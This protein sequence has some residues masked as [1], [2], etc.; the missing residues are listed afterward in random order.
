MQRTDGPAAPGLE[1]ADLQAVQSSHE[2][3]ELLQHLSALG[4]WDWDIETNVAIC[5]SSYHAL[6]GLPPESEFPSYEVWLSRLHPDDQAQASRDV[7]EALDGKGEYLSEYRVIWPDGTVH[8]L[9]GMGKVFFDEAGNPVRMIGINFDITEKVQANEELQRYREHLETLVEERTSAL[10]DRND[11]LQAEIRE[12]NRA[13][14]SLRASEERLLT[15][16]EGLNDAIIVHDEHGR[17]LDCNSAASRHLEY[18]ATELLQ[19]HMKDIESPEFAAGFKQRVAQQLQGGRFRCE[20]MHVTRDGSPVPV[21]VITS[22]IKFQGRDAILSVSRDIT[23]LK[24]ADDER[25]NLE[26]QVQHAQKLESLGVLAGGIAHDFNNLLTGILGHAEMAMDCAGGGGQIRREIESI[27]KSAK[28]AADL[29]RQMLAYSG[30]GRFVVQPLDLNGLITEIDELLKTSISK[31]A[32]LQLQL[33]D[34]L[35]A[36]EGDPAQI[37]QIVMNLVANASDALGGKSGTITV[38]T[39]AVRCT[40]EDLTKFRMDGDLEPGNYVS[41]EVSDTGHGMTEETRRKIF[42]PFFS[43]KFTGRGLGLAA[44][45][46][47]VRGHGGAIEVRSRPDQG[48]TFRLLFPGCDNPVADDT[49]RQPEPAAL[50]LDG[51]ILVA[52]DEETVRKVTT[53][54]LS[55]MGARVHTV[56]DGQEAVE[57]Y[58]DEQED[59]A[60]VILDLTMPRMGGEEAFR[61][62]REINPAA[63]IILASG[64]NSQEIAGHISASGLAGFIHKPFT[65]HELAR[66]VR[67]ALQFDNPAKG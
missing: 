19:M 36:I 52:D 6:Y 12:R 40:A 20:G 4:T 18:A 67:N 33:V 7:G 42:D 21:D 39:S 16:Y 10:I 5:S 61:A 38:A 53:R 25:R 23:D 37:G 58:R 45:Q 43:T 62:I 30:K 14:E 3:L 31:K 51:M 9:E 57:F 63:Q 59:I 35:P 47:I 24:K 46:G 1:S 44:V 60:C 65:R 34:D 26:R 32:D 29:C 13:E 56:C 17:I 48:A 8:W 66:V 49:E 2:R 27:V 55:H 41:L 64:Y 22:L 50:E 28:T 15:L 54:M 11:R